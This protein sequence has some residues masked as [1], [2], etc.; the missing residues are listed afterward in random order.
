MILRHLH[1]LA[2]H[3]PMGL[4]TILLLLAMFCKA[5]FFT[6]EKRGGSGW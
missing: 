6:P 5:V 1:D 4:A 2:Q 3:N